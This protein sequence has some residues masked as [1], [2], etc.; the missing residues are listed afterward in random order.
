MA[1]PFPF[2]VSVVIVFA[3]FLGLG[4]AIIILIINFILWSI[5]HSS[6][7]HAHTRA[8]EIS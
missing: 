5:F 3:L 6:A 1:P 8:L 2:E 7:S 4:G